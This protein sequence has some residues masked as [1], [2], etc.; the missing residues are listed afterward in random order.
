MSECVAINAQQKKGGKVWGVASIRVHSVPSRI[1][2]R[3]C[4]ALDCYIASNGKLY[5]IRHATDSFI[6]YDALVD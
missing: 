4:H 1:G 3:R 2:N 6:K 5:K